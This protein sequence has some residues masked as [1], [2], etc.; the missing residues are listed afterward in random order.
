M[1]PLPKMPYPQLHE[2]RSRFHFVILI[3]LI[4]I[5]AFSQEP[6]LRLHGTVTGAQNNTYIEVPFEVPPNTARLT[7][8]FHYTGKE[9]RTTLDLGIQDP[10]RFRGWSGGNKSSFTISASDATPSYLPGAVIAGTWKLL[11]GVPNIRPQSVASYAADVSFLR[12]ATRPVEFSEAPLHTEARWYRGDL[13]MHTAHSDGH[14]NSQS[15][16]QVP[17]P[18]FQTLDAAV[19]R[20][21]DFIAITDHNTTSQYN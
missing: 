2:P 21:L 11:I 13:H 19:R 17:C 16:K 20:G 8:S 1:M 10:Q 6:N 18:L 9:E 12:S 15:G 7:V 14:C 5:T 3:L 4:A